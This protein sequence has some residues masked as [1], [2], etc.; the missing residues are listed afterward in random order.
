M[1]RSFL[2]ETWIDAEE[3]AY[4]EGPLRES[5]RRGMVRFDDGKVRPVR[6]GVPDTAFSIPA[7]SGA[8]KYGFVSVKNEEFTFTV[9]S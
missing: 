1:V 8:G 7:R 3:L 9:R 4:G 6:L 5:P 2:G